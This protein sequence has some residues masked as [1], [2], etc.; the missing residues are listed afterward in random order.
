MLVRQD[1]VVKR[2]LVCR[3]SGLDILPVLAICAFAEGLAVE[4][5]THPV[6][7]HSDRSISAIALEGFRLRAAV[8]LWASRMRGGAGQGFGKP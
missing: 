8:S 2:V 5:S 6:G 7:K 4:P 3:A 1:K